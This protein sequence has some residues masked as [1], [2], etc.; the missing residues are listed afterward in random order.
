MAFLTVKKLSEAIALLINA[1]TDSNKSL[2]KDVLDIYDNESKVSGAANEM[3]FQVSMSI[4]RELLN[5]KVDVSNK[6]ERTLLLHN[7]KLSCDNDKY[8]RELDQFTDLFNVEE[9]L[10]DE[11]IAEIKRSLDNTVL[12]DLSFKYTKKL[13]SHV[14]KAT[15]EE[16]V[17]SQEEALESVQNLLPKI[18]TDIEKRK[19]KKEV[20]S[21]SKVS[22]IEDGSFTDAFKK[23]RAIKNSNTFIFGLQGLNRMFGDCGGL[24]LGKSLIFCAKTHNYKSGILLDF[25]CWITKYNAP[26][27]SIPTDPHTKGKPLMLFFSLENESSKNAL[28]IYNKIV[29]RYMTRSERAEIEALSGDELDEKR[30][31]IIVDFFR[32][33]GWELVIERFEPSEFSFSSFKASFDFYEENG[34]NVAFTIIDY[35]ALMQYQEN[36]Y[37]NGAQALATLAR[38]IINYTKHRS[39]SFITANQLLSDK[40]ANTEGTQIVRKFD[41]DYIAISK[42]IAN[43]FDVL[44]YLNKEFNQNNTPYLT[45]AW[46]KH[47]DCLRTPEAHKYFAYEFTE[48]GIMDDV[49]GKDMSLSN[50]Y[51]V[52]TDENATSGNTVGDTTETA[53]DLF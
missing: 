53:D 48:H 31:Q 35:M 14:A 12:T 45:A 26:P 5:G 11:K 7:M 4:L 34:Y 1:P 51:S 24:Q 36:S 21:F 52:T 29:Y 16:D 46:G 8:K 28:H 20:S 22:T 47:R 37:S 43:E 6:Q 32:S 17:D 15:N 3:P 44:F 27:K 9:K 2:V 30:S 42:A 50:I 10:S 13:F 41:V 33:R 25:P 19:V 38:N 39:C 18:I 23:E 49:A 40:V